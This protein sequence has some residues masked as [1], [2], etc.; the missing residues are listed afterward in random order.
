MA[1]LGLAS[2]GAGLVTHVVLFRFREDATSVD[3]EALLRELAKFPQRFAGMQRWR[4]GRNVSRRDGRFSHAFVVEF[5]DQADLLAYLADP[6][7]EAF[8]HDRWWPL[9]EERAIASVEH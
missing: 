4:L 6:W 9:I 3:R 5:A 2:R 8:V 7:H 1:R